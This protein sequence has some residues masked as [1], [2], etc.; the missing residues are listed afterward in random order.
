M[1]CWKK[2]IYMNWKEGKWEEW[3]VYYQNC[4]L[5][6]PHWASPLLYPLAPPLPHL[7]QFPLVL[8]A[9]QMLIYS[10]REERTKNKTR[11]AKYEQLCKME[12][13]CIILR[14]HALFLKTQ[15]IARWCTHMTSILEEIRHHFTI[16]VT[17]LSLEGQY[18]WNYTSEED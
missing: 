3:G 10:K 15:M 11:V 9:W 8:P 4:V 7:L 1:I 6:P 17:F 5:W 2:Y 12:P 14:W 18:Y 13:P 16:Q